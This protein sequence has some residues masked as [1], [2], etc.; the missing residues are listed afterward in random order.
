MKLENGIYV[1]ESSGRTFDANADVIGLNYADELTA[2]YDNDIHQYTMEPVSAGEVTVAEK[3]E[4]AEYMI[5][6][7]TDYRNA[8]QQGERRET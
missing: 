8:L 5:R 6:R 2:G 1:L 3:I 7:W 4:I